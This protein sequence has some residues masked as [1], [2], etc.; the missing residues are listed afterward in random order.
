MNAARE[1]VRGFGCE[2]LDVRGSVAYKS[3]GRIPERGKIKSVT[4]LE[5]GSICI[6]RAIYAF[7]GRF[8]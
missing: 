6:L 3:P 4:R 2:G 7:V 8:G 1:D 5:F